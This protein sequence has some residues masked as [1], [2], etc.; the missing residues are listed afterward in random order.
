MMLE[1][2]EVYRIMDDNLILTEPQ[3]SR[4]D[5]VKNR[6]L[7]LD[8]AKRL[9]DEQG[10]AA[11]SMAAIAEAAGVGKGTLYRHFENKTELC[12]ALLNCEDRDL[13]NETLRRLRETPDPLANLRWLLEARLAFV[14]RNE[15]LLCAG[16]PAEPTLQ[17]PANWW[18]RQTI[19]GL[20]EQLDPPG[21][22][23]YISDVLYIMLDVRTLH[24]Q[25]VT[26]GH[27]MTRIVEGVLATLDKLVG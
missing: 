5:A 2:S 24:F 12:R 9:F 22:L 15:P 27:D 26:V 16:D 11:V 17:H 21:D 8:T 7:L 18:V 3:P 25:I 6:A 4:A 10:V 19:R 13:Q 14:E 23:D 20:V 1:I